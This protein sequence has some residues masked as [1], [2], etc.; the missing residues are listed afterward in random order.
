[1]KK[2]FIWMLAATVGA[3]CLAKEKAEPQIDWDGPVVRDVLY[4]NVDGR[5]LGMDI[6]LPSGP[7]LEK[8]PV[9]YFVHGGGW[10]AGNKEKFGQAN[11]LGV[12]RQLSAKGFICVSVSYRLCRTGSSVVMRDCVTDV[13]DGLRFLKK[14][15]AE[16]GID[17]TRIVVFGESAGGQLVQM[18]TLADPDVFKGD[19]ALASYKVQPLAG[20]SWYGPTDFT[21]VNLFK[22][23]LSDKD[24]NRFGS[25]ITG[26]KGDYA[27]NPK[28]YEEMSSVF[29]IKKDSPPLLLMQGD[30]DATIP[31]AHAP[32]LKKRA[33]QIGADV[34][35]VTVK[36]AGHNWRKAGG[37]PEPGLEEIQRITVEYAT[38]QIKSA[39]NKP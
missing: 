13:M 21:D 3:S 33:D 34:T 5:Q 38:K 27:T 9:L 11:I 16:Y 35:M 6:Y 29:W 10:A 31:F 17:P 2:I 24:P 1:M 18:L 20:M 32:R 4:K 15:A 25:R 7:K 23:D 26:G 22:T 14:N 39:K 19:K 8:A 28:A 12:G 30:T 37:N 36:H